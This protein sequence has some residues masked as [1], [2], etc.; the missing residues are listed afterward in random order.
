MAY[1]PI[2]LPENHRQ[3]FA[4][5][6]LPLLNENVRGD[7]I[8]VIDGSS[9]S[10]V[11]RYCDYITTRH[12]WGYE[13]EGP[14]GLAFDTLYHFTRDY[15][16]SCA[17]FIEFASRVYSPLDMKSNHVVDQAVIEGF[18]REKTNEKGGA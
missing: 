5:E 18:I 2:M 7:V 6:R 3:D 8:L 4:N 1:E 12:T 13:G 15:K 17:F 10:N 16:F 14:R 11:P 9:Y